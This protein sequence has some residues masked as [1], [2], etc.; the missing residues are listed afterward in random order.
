MKP[1]VLWKFRKM[2]WR[3]C[4]IAAMA[5]GFGT[6]RT[7]LNVNADWLIPTE[8]YLYANVYAEQDEKYIIQKNSVLTFTEINMKYNDI[9][10][11]C[12]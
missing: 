2:T 3:L 11:T 5:K 12:I 10:Q 6:N 4:R 9:Y 8:A 7:G 1:N